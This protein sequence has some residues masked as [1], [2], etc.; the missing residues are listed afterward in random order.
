MMTTSSY[1]FIKSSSSSG[2]NESLSDPLFS[3]ML[4][5]IIIIVGVVNL[6]GYVGRLMYISP[7][8]SEI[9]GGILL[10]SDLF[11]NHLLSKIFNDNNNNF[12]L[13][14]ELLSYYGMIFYVFLCGMEIQLDSIIDIANKYKPSIA[15][16]F[17]G[18]IFPFGIGIAVSGYLYHIMESQSNQL[19]NHFKSYKFICY[20]IFIS[21]A[22]S[23]VE[24]LMTNH[25][26]VENQFNKFYIGNIIPRSVNINNLYVIIA[27]VCG[28]SIANSK[29]ITNGIIVASM[30]GGFS[31]IMVIIIRPIFHKLVGIIEHYGCKSDDKD[32]INNEKY[33]L[34]LFSLL[35]CMIFISSWVG[36]ILGCHP[37]IGS[38]LIGL[39]VPRHS[40]V[41]QT[42]Q[43]GLT[44][45]IKSF[46]IP[47]Y[48]LLSGIRT[49]I[50]LFANSQSI[51]VLVF[52]IIVAILSKLVPIYGTSFFQTF[53]SHESFIISMILNSKG[54]CVVIIANIGYETNIIP[55]KTFT[56]LIIISIVND[57]IIYSPLLNYVYPI[58]NRIKSHQR[59]IDT[60]SLEK[61]VINGRISNIQ[62]IE[63]GQKSQIIPISID[64]SK[65]SHHIRIG[66]IMYDGLDQ[67]NDEVTNHIKV[68][69][70]DNETFINVSRILTCFLPFQNN[71]TVAITIMNTIQINKSINKSFHHKEA[72][73]K[74]T[75]EERKVQNYN[76]LL[77]PRE[78]LYL[79][80]L[81]Y[82]CSAMA[83][84]FNIFQ[85]ESESHSQFPSAI[86]LLSNSND[87]SMLIMPWNNIQLYDSMKEKSYESTN[88]QLFWS[89][90]GNIVSIPIGILV[91][92]VSNET[93][94][95]SNEQNETANNNDDN[96]NRCLDSFSNC[97]KVKNNQATNKE[98]KTCSTLNLKMEEQNQQITNNFTSMACIVAVIT[99]HP[100]DIAIFPILLKFSMNK[101]ISIHVIVPCD[102]K[103]FEKSNRIAF[104]DFK[105]QSS[106]IMNIHIVILADI[107]STDNINLVNFVNEL[108]FDLLICSN[109][110]NMDDTNG[111]IQAQTS[112]KNAIFNNIFQNKTENKSTIPKSIVD[113]TLPF[114]ELGPLACGIKY[115][116]NSENGLCY[117]THKKGSQILVLHCIDRE[118]I[119][120]SDRPSLVKSNSI[121]S[122]NGIPSYSSAML[123]RS[124][125]VNSNSITSK[126]GIPSYSS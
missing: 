65:L 46:A 14:L 4:L 68:G 107:D 70:S 66:F 104:T 76:H 71:S 56:M 73:S 64:N 99:G 41:Y 98:Y 125:L 63:S 113:S 106:L 92:I 42:C 79:H 94:N 20:C 90:M 58:Q 29:S 43:S 124:S 88:R 80:L 116:I 85:I 118:V 38:L 87:L 96:T 52:I 72:I 97:F 55:E 34:F 11:S 57:I 28:V 114:P 26:L 10:G 22:F 110:T 27:L 25:L 39:T 100:M 50:T 101:N 51:G 9:I 93:M 62:G 84:P 13:H 23:V 111:S 24:S 112:T 82:F 61:I 18:M 91:D 8:S 49:N 3:R 15:I 67:N 81:S 123:E 108:T 2:N 30:V 109:S 33:S 7:S 54:F 121:T 35:I 5:Q 48:L 40:K 78:D 103:S 37:F 119:T 36:L 74:L 19:Y 45:I 53:T 32:Y 1:S 117:K 44:P 95:N 31:L 86:Q 59:N 120:I 115:G 77:I 102:R 122:K 126:N 6:F 21:C 17:I 16:G 12:M 89:L 47:L 75:I 105:Q 69:N 60:E 83:I